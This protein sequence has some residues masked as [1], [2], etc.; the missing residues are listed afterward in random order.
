MAI[1]GTDVLRLKVFR[2]LLGQSYL[3]VGYFL[4]SR[5]ILGGAD[6]DAVTAIFAQDLCSVEK[7]LQS[8]QVTYIRVEADSPQTPDISTYA[9]DPGVV[10]NI[11]GDCLPASSAVSVLLRRAS[12]I[13][14]N[15][16]KRFSG[17]PEAQQSNGA[18][19]PTYR[20]GFDDYANEFWG[21][22]RVFAPDGFATITLTPI[23]YR[24]EDLPNN[25]F[26]KRNAILQ[27]EVAP[28]LGTQNTRKQNPQG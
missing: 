5:E 12:K 3:S 16:Y 24:E 1:T 25:Q 6:L 14:R 28:F 20:T 15:G 2:S 19:V 22:P 13:T 7:V 8:A 21:A 11:S 10:G 9:Y 27:A 23:I 26:E 17:V 18:L 4:V